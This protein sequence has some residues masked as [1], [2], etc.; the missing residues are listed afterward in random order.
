MRLTL[1]LLCRVRLALCRASGAG[2]MG[3]ALRS[4]DWRAIPA[5]E[6]R[7]GLCTRRMAAGTDLSDGPQS[8]FGRGWRSPLR[9]A[10]R[11]TVKG[12]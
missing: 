8:D 9:L 5:A 3:L 6:I 11:C 12:A 10:F 7:K 4:R 2:D 1:L